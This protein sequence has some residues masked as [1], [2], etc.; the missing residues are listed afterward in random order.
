[1]KLLWGKTHLG[2]SLGWHLGLVHTTAQ[3]QGGTSVPSS[4][5]AK[6]P[7]LWRLS[8]V[9]QVKVEPSSSGASQRFSWHPARVASR[10]LSPAVTPTLPTGLV[11]NLCAPVHP[12]AEHAACMCVS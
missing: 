4:S 3:R 9:L 7:W 10:H 11:P 5:M 6:L 12:G 8:K 1:M 2:E